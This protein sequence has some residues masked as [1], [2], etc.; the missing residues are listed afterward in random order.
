MS[1][2][3]KL[4]RVGWA[5]ST[6]A[7]TSC[8]VWRSCCVRALRALRRSGRA[9]V[10]RAVGPSIASV[11]VVKSDTYRSPHARISPSGGPAA[12]A[13]ADRF[14]LIEEQRADR[15][16]LADQ[17]HFRPTL[18]RLLQQDPQLQTRERGP[19]TEVPAAGAERLMLGVALDVEHV[20]ALVDRL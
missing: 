14:L 1:A 9:R 16:R 7:L 15:V 5:S 6:K 2:S 17:L 18:D 12:N 3:R 10:R 20:R 13:D 19:E 8:L 11:S 4:C